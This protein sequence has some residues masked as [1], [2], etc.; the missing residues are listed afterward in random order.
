MINLLIR[1]SIQ[2]DGLVGFKLGSNQLIRLPACF[3][4]VPWCK[5][6]VSLLLCS[7]R[8]AFGYASLQLMT[9]PQQKMVKES[10]WQYIYLIKV[11]NLNSIKVFKLFKWI[12]FSATLCGGYRLSLFMKSMELPV[13]FFVLFFFQVTRSVLLRINVITGLP[14]CPMLPCSCTVKD[15]CFVCHNTRDVKHT[16]E[17]Q[18]SGSI[19]FGRLTIHISGPSQ[20]GLI[21]EL[22]YCFLDTINFYAG[23]VS[24]HLHWRNENFFLT[25]CMFLVCL[26]LDL[27]AAFSCPLTSIS[28]ILLPCQLREWF[29]S[30]IFACWLISV[31]TGG[32]G[33]LC[34]LRLSVNLKAGC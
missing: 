11:F 4:A 10:E 32:S 7:S 24:H 17:P 5:T 28:V 16:D 34:V 26:L 20:N 19:D 6:A 30:C 18:F 22:M 21:S 25:A 33:G 15:I 3:A 31:D 27:K 8:E 13:V 12:W 2:K 9:G 14:I 29:S 1:G 23:Y